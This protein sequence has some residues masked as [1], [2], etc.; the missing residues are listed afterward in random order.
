MLDVIL[1]EDE[2]VLREELGGFLQE[3]GYA[4]LCLSNLE[5]FEQAFDPQ[6]HRLAVIDI[7]L[8]D[9]CGLELVRRLRAASYPVGIVIYSARNAVADK[10]QGL[11]LGADHYLDKGSS[12]DV[13]A[14]TLAALV[15]R[16]KLRPVA[17]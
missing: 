4:P 6:R 9:G 14:A 2:P 8:P 3:Q 1:L 7:G 13:L 12:L 17:D 10:I 11:D 15:R 16:L 5:E